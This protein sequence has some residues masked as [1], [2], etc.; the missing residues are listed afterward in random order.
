[1]IDPTRPELLH[2]LETLSGLDPEQRFG[3]LISNL[4]GLAI[5]FT[6]TAT[7]DVKDIE[8]LATID[9]HTANLKDRGKVAHPIDPVR[10]EILRRLALLSEYV[11][12]VRFGQTILDVPHPVI[13][14]RVEAIWNV[15]DDELLAAINE[16]ILRFDRLGALVNPA[17]SSGY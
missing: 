6:Y 15:E 14:P 12:N 8:L 11:P 9:E 2:R 4:A 10:L 1:M 17:S 16:Q 13:G 5:G 7:E 3:Q